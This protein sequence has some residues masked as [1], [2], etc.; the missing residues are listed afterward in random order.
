MIRYEE[1]YGIRPSIPFEGFSDKLLII[2]DKLKDEAKIQL[3]SYLIK[4]KQNKAEDESTIMKNFFT[5]FD[6]LWINVDYRKNVIPGK[7][8]FSNL[9]QWLTDQ[10]HISLPIHYVINRLLYEEIDNE[11]VTAINDFIK[12]IDGPN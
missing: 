8:F 3:L 7:E 1:K 2:I 4:N 9:S 5:K 10:Y 11:I 12:F 6:D